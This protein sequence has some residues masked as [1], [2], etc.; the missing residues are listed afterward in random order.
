LILF[1][2]KIIAIPTKFWQNATDFNILEKMT[3]DNRKQVSNDDKEKNFDNPLLQRVEE[4]ESQLLSTTE[5]AEQAEAQ[6]SRALADLANFQRRETENRGK[7]SEMAISDFLKKSLP[8]FLELY[9]GSEH[10]EDENFHQVV[11]KFFENLAKNGLEK[12]SPV[13][14]DSIDPDLH[15]V[16]MVAEGEPGKVVK[17]LE[18]GWKFND[19]VI[20][21]A[22][23][24]GASE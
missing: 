21:P 3:K 6:M 22:K 1:F 2:S 4:L 8:S 23:I 9:L 24:S 15:E 5:R 11:N 13:A 12:I 10:S 14:G 20:Q 18:P 19:T 7:W 17:V 16:L